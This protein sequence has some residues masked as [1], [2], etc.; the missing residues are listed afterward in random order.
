MDRKSG[1]FSSLFILC[2]VL[3]WTAAVSAAAPADSRQNSAAFGDGVYALF[4]TTKGEIAA[5][6]YYKKVPL[7]VTNFVGLAEGTIQSHQAPG[8]KYYDGIVFHRVIKDFMIQGGDPT[9]TGRGGPGYRFPDE[10]REDLKHDSAGI[11]SMANAGPGTNGSQFFITHKATPWLDGKHTVFGKVVK[12]QG[13]VDAIEQGDKI[14]TLKIIRNG[15]DAEA[16]KSGQEQFDALLSKFKEKAEMEQEKLVKEFQAG[17]QKA[18]PD[19]KPAESGLMYVYK[20]DGEGDKPE[21]GSIVSVHYTG[22]FKDGKVFDSS[23][24]RGQPIE[25]RVGMGQVIPGWDLALLDMQKGEART[26][27]IPYWLAYGE[28][29]YPG[30]IPPKSDLIFEVELVD[31]K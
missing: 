15:K 2:S 20:K 19:A 13:V 11:L 31:I 16:F 21:K 29:G 28:R 1:F 17:M 14:I 12:G 3:I 18:Y 5:E 24:E 4:E 26:L 27:L 10:F 7:T 30:A 8:K 22:R 23:V 9:G 6:L 25:F